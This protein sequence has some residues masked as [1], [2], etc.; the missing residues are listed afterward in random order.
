MIAQECPHRVARR[1]R[2]LLN[3][4][5]RVVHF[6]PFLGAGVEVLHQHPFFGHLDRA[7]SHGALRALDRGG[8][9]APAPLSHTYL[10][11]GSASQAVMELVLSL[12]GFLNVT[13]RR[14]DPAHQ[15]YSSFF[16]MV[17]LTVE[18]PAQ[19][20]VGQVVVDLGWVDLNFVVECPKS[21]ST[22][23]T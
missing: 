17:Y 2:F 11:H 16:L 18:L 23:L 10:I 3:C 12:R 5:H 6:Q 9:P 21:M 20:R 13:C 8:P 22:Q 15:N 14:L 19:Y 1:P 7:A 4:R